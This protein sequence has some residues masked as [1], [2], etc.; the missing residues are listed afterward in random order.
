MVAVVALIL[1]LR[2]PIADRLWPVAN[3]EA[4]RQQAEI[5][6]QQGRLSAED[7]S[8]ARELFEAAVA[9]DPD[10]AELR[11]G[12][13]R[14]AQAAVQQ[15]RS[16]TG[17]GAFAEAHRQLK[18]A[19]ALSAPQAQTE[20]VGEILRRREAAVAGIDVLLRAADAARAA[21]RLDGA[22]DAALPLYR[23]ILEL[24]PQHLQALEGRED[25]LTL[26]LQ[27]ARDALKRD[28]FAAAADIATAQA[29]DRGHPDLP[30]SQAAMT[31][32]VERLRRRADA[33]L[34]A[35]RLQR[36][37]DGYRRWQA[38]GVDTLAANDA[39]IEVARAHTRQ[40]REAAADFRFE[41]ARLSLA[42]ARAL[43]P[44]LVD[45]QQTHDAIVRAERVRNGAGPPLSARTVQRR[46]RAL[47]AEA[48]EAESRGDWLTPP[49]DS[50]Y[51]KLRA[52]RGLAPDDAEVH[53]A[54]AR[55]LPRVRECFE[56]ELRDNRLQRARVCLDAQIALDSDRRAAAAARSRLA[57][58]WVALGEQRLSGG[59]LDG[60][61]AAHDAARELDPRGE[62][63]AAFA[64]R[65]RAAGSV[66][67]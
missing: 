39:L 4:L 63:L 59:E 55:M 43:A 1:L 61:R 23:R 67:R 54:S 49:G 24:Q 7:G 52:A 14:V 6:L 19:R 50:A 8:G 66:E 29:Y 28:D 47:L 60:A 16:A 46:V 37:A 3:A 5:A 44:D 53:R 22:A 17:R 56:K 41:R 33:D 10:R 31:Q 38:S 57:Q 45:V 34:R 21:G 40:A 13:S 15:A 48:A 27:R 11:S 30:E 35:G 36:A 65:L 12:L 25:A 26:L 51:D 32:A 62:G 2:G 9:I 18:L 58:R 42:Q 64:E 20:A